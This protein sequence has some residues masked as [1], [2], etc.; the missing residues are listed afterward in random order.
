VEGHGVVAA[1]GVDPS[2]RLPD[3]QIVRLF[4]RLPELILVV[5]DA[6]VIVHA[7]RTLLETMGYELDGVVG[8]SIFDYVHP[9]ELTYMAWSWESRTAE[10]GQAGLIVQGRARNA[11]GTWRVLE[12]VGLSLLE[13]PGCPYVVVTMRDIAN[14]AALADSP[15]RLRSMIDRTTDIVLLV[16]ADGRFVYANRRLTARFGHDHDKVVGQPWTTILDPEDVERAERWFE[17]LVGDGESSTS[18]ERFR[19]PDPRGPVYDV[20]WRGTNQ[21]SDPLIEGVIM[22]GRDITDLVDM[23]RRL[24]ERNAELLRASRH[25]PLTGLLNRPAFVD[26]VEDSLRARRERGD[27]G[28]VVML[29]CD[30][31]S[32][33]AINDR[34]GH[35]IG[36]RVL[37]AVGERLVETVRGGDIVGRYGGDEFTILLS[38]S[39]SIPTVT[40]LVARLK[41][42]IGEPI[43][44]GDLVVR[45]GVSIGIGRAGVE[46]ADVDTLLHSA[47][48]AMYAHKR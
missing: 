30:L 31:D 23:E 5:D 13:E 10:S 12:I 26:L 4:D 22:S 27:A 35:T 43:V 11:D 25:D 7:N 47:D 3:E 32:F 45:V 37:E 2:R 34:N 44:C 19:V 15:G 33:K 41:G 39:A 24:R 36:D 1:D 20:D 17:K 38:D 21:I 9:D 42:A 18:T 46:A 8:S 40:G 28:E 16:D 29:F 14:Q 48:E 6:G